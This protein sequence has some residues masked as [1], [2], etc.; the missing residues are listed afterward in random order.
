[1]YMEA[2]TSWD[3]SGVKAI[4]KE[5]DSLTVNKITSR[6]R[7]SEGMPKIESWIAM[8]SNV[9]DLQPNACSEESLTFMR[10]PIGHVTLLQNQTSESESS[11]C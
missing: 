1:M 6:C 5:T 7:S 4:L 10:Q 11:T 8:A 3:I 2:A 9:V